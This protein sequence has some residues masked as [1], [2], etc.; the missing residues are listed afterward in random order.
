MNCETCETLLIDHLHGEL[1]SADRHAVAGHLTECSECALAFCRLAADVEGIAAAYEVVPSASARNEL[2]ERVSA[3][4]RPSLL[5][6]AWAFATRPVP[7]YGVACAAA[8][9]L[10]LWAVSPAPPATQETTDPAPAASKPAR[11][12]DYDASTSLRDPRIL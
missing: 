8:I 3:E 12:H 2:R 4:F 1:P 9:P 7:A 11:I 5:R 10:L 6:R